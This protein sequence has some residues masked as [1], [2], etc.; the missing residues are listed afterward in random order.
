MSS[1]ARNVAANLLAKIWAVLMSLAVVPV[2]IRA[3]GME[4]YGLLG[5]FLSL[6]AIFAV[7]DLG[8]GNSLNRQLAQYSVQPG[9]EQ[10]TRDLLR[11]LESIY[12]LVGIVAGAATALLAPL[13]AAH[14]L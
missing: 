7:L 2:Y 9:S 12:W 1:V 3:L 6:T 14:W 10:Q 11:T 5:F 4:A 13:I 8:L